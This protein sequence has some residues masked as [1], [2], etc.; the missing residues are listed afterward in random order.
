MTRDIPH[1]FRHLLGMAP[2]S[3]KLTVC[4]RQLV[5]WSGFQAVQLYGQQ[6]NFLRDAIMQLTANSSALFLLSLD[7]PAGQVTGAV[8]VL[9]QF[10]LTFPQLC[11][12]HVPL[13]KENG[14]KH[15]GQSQDGK[16]QL[17]KMHVVSASDKKMAPAAARCRIS[18]RAL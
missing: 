18:R 2:Q 12:Y 11:F 14:N 15:D 7:E 6:C 5:S 4:L 13:F 10:F 8:V 17:Q 9:I 16:K 3:S 1:A